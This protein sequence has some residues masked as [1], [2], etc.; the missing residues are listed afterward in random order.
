MIIRQLNITNFRGIKILQWNIPNERIICLIGACDVGKSTILKAIDLL[1]SDRWNIAISHYDFNSDESPIVI[2]AVLTNLPPSL[3][4]TDRLG[5]YEAGLNKISNEVEE[6]PSKHAEACLCVRLIIDNDTYEP[7]WEVFN[8]CSGEKVKLTTGDRR[9]LGLSAFDPKADADIKWTRNSALGK[10]ANKNA[11][12]MPL[13]KIAIEAA[14]KAL[15]DMDTPEDVKRVLKCV[16]DKA[17]GFGAPA[18][19]D[20]S[21]GLEE[22]NTYTN[23]TISLYAEDIPL[24]LY[25]RGTKTLASLAIQN[26]NSGEST[27]YLIDEIET[28]LEPHRII[29]LLQLLETDNTIAQAFIASHSNVVVEYCECKNIFVVTRDSSNTKV[30]RVPDELSSLHRTNPS[31]LLARKVLVVEGKTEEG[32]LKT[33]IIH[34]NANNRNIGIPVSGSYGSTICQGSGGAQ[35]CKKANELKLLGVEVAL[36]LDGDDAVTNDQADSL[37]RSGI[38]VYMWPNSKCT[39]RALA[40]CLDCSGVKKLIERCLDSE[41]ITEEQALAHLKT[42]GIDGSYSSIE[43]ID[44]NGLDKERAQDIFFTACTQKRKRKGRT[45]DEGWFKGVNEGELL[46]R[47]ILDFEDDASLDFSTFTNVLEDALD[48]FFFE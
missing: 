16:K 17:N 9:E 8:P 48:G 44:W 38:S 36:F 26:L 43:E 19:E 28:G 6:A 27:S 11:D 24:T 21:I 7:S 29:H 37:R 13:S 46:G 25:G 34:R 23:G 4:T 2:D 40:D 45:I 22:A 35:A 14:R 10:F 5:F 39:E 12:S 41:I 47:I 3:R 20:L 1:L 18:I 42:A 33:L 30:V 31:S 15:H 32:L